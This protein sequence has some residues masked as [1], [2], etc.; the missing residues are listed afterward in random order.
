MVHYGIGK[1]SNSLG[2]EDRAKAIYMIW[3][4]V[5]FAPG[6]TSFGKISI[7]LFLM[8]LIHHQRL[9]KS[10]LWVLIIFLVATWAMIVVITFAQCTPTSF[11][12][13]HVMAG[14]HGT[15][16]PETVFLYSAY[17]QAGFSAW[18]D[19]ILAL[20]PIGLIWNMHLSKATKFGIVCLMSLGIIA[21]GAGGVKTV[22]LKHLA[23][24]DLT[25]DVV[26]LIYWIA[27]EAWIIIICACVPTIKPLFNNGE[28]RLRNIYNRLTGKCIRSPPP[29]FHNRSEHP[30]YRLDSVNQPLYGRPLRSF[31]QQG[32]SGCR[33]ATASSV[34]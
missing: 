25:W 34:S 13:E 14:T 33:N 12:W 23:S 30:S 10:F 3:L 19:L 17:F 8:N 16:W 2:E 32:F 15:C 4:N 7:A 5:P 21:A 27:A 31:K 20:Y 26:P 29:T 9:Q 1:H 6:S 28:W 24:S 11:L 18:S 22:E